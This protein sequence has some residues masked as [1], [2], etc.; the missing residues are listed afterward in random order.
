MDTAC[1]HGTCTWQAGGRCSGGMHARSDLARLR[2]EELLAISEEDRGVFEGGDD[3]ERE[4][5]VGR[6]AVHG[7]DE[8]KVID[9]IE[10]IDEIEVMT[11]SR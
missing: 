5:A 3:G 4:R 9:E 7:D 11:G 1:A 2:D 8:V 10:A 6:L